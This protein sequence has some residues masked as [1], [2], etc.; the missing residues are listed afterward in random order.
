[1]HDTQQVEFNLSGKIESECEL[2]VN[3]C[4]YM[5]EKTDRRVLYTKMVLKQSLLDLLRMRPIE[6]I[7]VK[8]IC[9]KADIN[10]GTFYTH[11]A[12]PYDLLAQIENELVGEIMASIESSLKADAI[13]SLL[14]KILASIQKSSD[15]CT[16]LFSDYGDKAFLKRIINAARG[17]SMAEWKKMI[18]SVNDEQMELLYLF[19]A[20]GCVAIIQHWVLSGMKE[21]PQALSE[22]LEKLSLKG[23]GAY[24]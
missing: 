18:P 5:S 4:V 11:F 16:V 9:E 22:M 19:Y 6:K 2:F 20:S 23:L 14:V 1:M 17:Q 7:T 24:V 21:S 12:D 8:D 10:R 3:G 13:S 15:L